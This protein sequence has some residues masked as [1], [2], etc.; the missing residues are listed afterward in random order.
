M[1]GDPHDLR[2]WGASGSFGSPYSWVPLYGAP[3]R[4]PNA[5]VPGCRGLHVVAN[6]A[7]PSSQY[8]CSHIL[9]MYLKTIE[10]SSAHVLLLWAFQGSSL[11]RV[12]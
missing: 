5:A 2:A 11:R 4:F 7:V 12:N 3:F 8:T 6:S 10:I 9:R 1:G